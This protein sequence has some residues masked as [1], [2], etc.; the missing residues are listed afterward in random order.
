MNYKAVIQKTYTAFLTVII[1]TVFLMPQSVNANNTPVQGELVSYGYNNPTIVDGVKILASSGAVLGESDPL[2]RL[3]DF[4]IEFDVFDID[5]FDHL[6]VYIALYNF[7]S[8]DSGVLAT[9]INS[10]V[11]DNALVLR[12]IAPERSIYLSGLYL[13]GLESGLGETFNFVIESGKSNFLVKS[14]TTPLIVDSYNSGISDFKTPSVFN[15][16]NNVTWQVTTTALPT[17]SGL[18]TDSGL[19]TQYVNGVEDSSGLRNIKY[20][21][22]IPIKMSKV[23]PSSGVWNLGVLVYDRLQ[24]EIIDEKTNEISIHDAY[25]SRAYSNLFYGEVSIVGGSGLTFIDVAA[26]SGF[27]TS[28]SGVTVRFIS[29]GIYRQQVQADTTWTPAQT[30]PNRPIFAYL[31]SS[32]TYLEANP[33]DEAELDKGNRFA[34]Q[35]RRT[36]IG[37]GGG[38]TSFV[39]IEL[40]D[41]GTEVLIPLVNAVQTGSGPRIYRESLTDQDIRR[42]K[43]VTISN[44]TAKTTEVGVDSDFEFAL[45]LSE[46]FQ[47]TTYTGGISIGV[48]NSVNEFFGG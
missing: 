8:T 37:T 47:N 26:G 9:V 25:A 45:K 2:D 34:L 11:N 14:G 27:E 5:G 4:I 43:I 28:D 16:Q 30:V 6:D 15:D 31:V 46:V 29:N 19:V 23:A 38:S 24:Q 10:G 40:P 12:W 42:S 39:D 36:R 13:S 17:A 1:F 35:A 48:S 44:D 20:K 33:T 18:V 32:G 3:A 21:V 22:Q 7:A 41:Y